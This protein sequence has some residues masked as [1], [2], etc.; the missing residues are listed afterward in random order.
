MRWSA[1]RLDEYCATKLNL[2]RE[3]SRGSVKTEH[4]EGLGHLSSPET[5]TFVAH[6]KLLFLYS[7]DAH[8][9]SVEN[10]S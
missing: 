6:F 9:K 4:S 7:S 10:K 2:F 5:Q 8:D 3:I 1:F